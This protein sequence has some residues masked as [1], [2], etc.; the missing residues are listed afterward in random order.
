MISDNRE[1]RKLEHLR[2]LLKANSLA[3]KQEEFKSRIDQVT[4]NYCKIMDNSLEYKFKSNK[5]SKRLFE[6]TALISQQVRQF[7]ETIE[8]YDTV[9]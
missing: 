1:R 7:A 6:L 2:T 4:A 3:D 9:C 5:K 8:I